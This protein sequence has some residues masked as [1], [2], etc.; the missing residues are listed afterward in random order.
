[1]TGV[2]GRQRLESNGVAAQQGELGVH[3]KLRAAELPY[4]AVPRRGA[5]TMLRILRSQMHRITKI[6]TRPSSVRASQNWHL[7]P[8]AVL[9]ATICPGD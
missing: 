1:M 5:Q 8:F 2:G 4:A 9:V 6:A 7:T 3:Q